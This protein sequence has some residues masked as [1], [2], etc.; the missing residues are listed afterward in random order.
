MKHIAWMAG[1]LI[2]SG[3][4]SNVRVY[5]DIARVPATC[6][7]RIGVQ[8]RLT[9]SSTD[10]G[11]GANELEDRVLKECKNSTAR[12]GFNALLLK[13]IAKSD[14]LDGAVSMRCT[15]VAYEC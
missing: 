4:A 14:E 12:L 2:T 5:T 1:A 7:P 13:D 10:A 15:G 9:F 6:Q 3:C 8:Q 11:L